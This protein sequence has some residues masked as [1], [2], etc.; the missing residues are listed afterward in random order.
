MIYSYIDWDE[1]AVAGIYYDPRKPADMNDFLTDFKDD[2]VALHDNALQHGGNHV[3]VQLSG[4]CC[5][6][7][8]TTFIL[9]IAAHNAYYG[10]RKCTTKS[11]RVRKVLHTNDRRKTGGR[12]TFPEPDAPLRTDYSFRNRLQIKNHNKN[13]RKSFLERDIIGDVVLDYMHLVGIGV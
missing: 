9:N 13:R 3:K 2:T 10:G 6:S 4:I 8:A 12:V 7:P 11:T 5:D 1:I